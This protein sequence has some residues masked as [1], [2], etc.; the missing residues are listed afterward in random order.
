MQRPPF[1]PGSGL[2]SLRSVTKPMHRLLTLISIPCSPLQVPTW[3]VVNSVPPHRQESHY[4]KR[5][6]RPAI[7]EPILP[8]R[9]RS[10]LAR[11]AEAARPWIHQRFRR[12][13][14]QL[15][16][17]RTVGQQPYRM[18]LQ[19]TIMATLTGRRAT[20]RRSRSISL[21]S[22]CSLFSNLQEVPEVHVFIY[23][24]PKEEW[25]QG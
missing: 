17:C 25:G 3:L 4:S 11:V 12:S 5:A 13:G 8:T 18:C 9:P 24:L 16:I 15:P 14:V 19:H 21:R 20:L 6:V 7:P 23:S 1:V 22:M 2:F 10:T